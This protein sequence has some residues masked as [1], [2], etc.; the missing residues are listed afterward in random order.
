MA[1][2]AAPVEL[3][4]AIELSLGR[5]DVVFERHQLPVAEPVELAVQGDVD[6]QQSHHGVACPVLGAKRTGQI[7]QTAALG[8]D[9]HRRPVHALKGLRHGPVALQGP[10]EGLREAAREVEPAERRRQVRILERAEGYDLGPLLLEQFEVLR[11]VEVEGLVVGDADPHPVG[12]RRGTL[13]DLARNQ[14]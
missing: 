7:H 4:A 1:G 5:E 8:V 13:E 9:R 2:D 12:T 11:V 10:D 6:R 3:V 14:G